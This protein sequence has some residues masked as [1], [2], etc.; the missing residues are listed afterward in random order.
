M[1][2]REKVESMYVLMP[3][4]AGKLNDRIQKVRIACGISQNELARRVD[5][6]VQNIQKI[7]QG[8]T[9]TIN[10]E[11]LEAICKALDYPVKKLMKP[12]REELSLDHVETTAA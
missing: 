12:E 9:R 5:M 11:T 2:K 3:I 4:E 7:E 1:A 10:Y 6:T 8:Y